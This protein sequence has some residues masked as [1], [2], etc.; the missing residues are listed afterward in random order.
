[1]GAPI[2]KAV[3]YY[4]SVVFLI[5]L[6]VAV[7]AEVGPIGVDDAADVQVALGVVGGERALA[8]L[9]VEGVEVEVVDVDALQVQQ[10]AQLEAV[11][12]QPLLVPR[13]QSPRRVKSLLLLFLPPLGGDGLRLVLAEGEEL[14][15]LALVDVAH[16]GADVGEEEGEVVLEEGEVGGE[17]AVA[18]DGELGDLGLRADVAVVEE[19]DVEKVQQVAALPRL[20]VRVQVLIHAVCHHALA[21][22]ASGQTYITSPLVSCLTRYSCFR[23]RASAVVRAFSATLMIR[24]FL[25]STRFRS[26]SFTMEA[27]CSPSNSSVLRWSSR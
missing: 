3:R 8:L 26:S 22:A 25:T 10:P 15:L 14:L 1:V 27:S 24:K 18:Q 16:G 5:G 2:Y 9:G 13:P 20:V 19:E 21:G 4:S 7:G 23:H 6:A 11:L 17:G 12:L